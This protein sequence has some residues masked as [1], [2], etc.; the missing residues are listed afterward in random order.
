MVKWCYM[1]KKAGETVDHLLLHCKYVSK[2]WSLILCLFVVQ[3]VMPWKHC[4]GFV[5]LER[6]L[7][8]KGVRRW[9]GLLSIKFFLLFKTTHHGWTTSVVHRPYSVA[10]GRKLEGVGKSSP[11]SSLKE[12]CL[13][14][15]FIV[16]NKDALVLSMSC[17]TREGGP[18]FWTLKFTHSFH[19]WDWIVKIT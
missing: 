6:E 19:D 12:M 18:H 3:W 4:G 1:H 16:V 17:Y 8:S 10:N 5:L 9:F 15:F 2:L 14:L 7:C 13:D 11:L